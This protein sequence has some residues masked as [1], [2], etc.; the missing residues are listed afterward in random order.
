MYQHVTYFIR[1]VSI[2]NLHS[3]YLIISN[4][5]HTYTVVLFVELDCIFE[6]MIKKGENITDEIL[7]SYQ[8]EKLF[9]ESRLKEIFF[10]TFSVC[11]HYSALAAHYFATFAR[12]NI[13]ATMMTI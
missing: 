10:S 1:D 9:Q 13:H 4:Y 12:D 8:Y 7:P 3:E 6:H 11:L 2:I 5:K